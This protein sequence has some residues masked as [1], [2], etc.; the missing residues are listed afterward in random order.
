VNWI[1]L[2]QDRHK[3]RAFVKTV[4]NLLV[5]YIAGNY[6]LM[7]LVRV[8]DDCVSF[9]GCND[10]FIVVFVVCDGQLSIF[11]TQ[12][13]TVFAVCLQTSRSHRTEG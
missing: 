2:T 8:S 7:L 4:M 5:P 11:R 12:S 13:F 10:V 1:L 3:W 9:V 6:L